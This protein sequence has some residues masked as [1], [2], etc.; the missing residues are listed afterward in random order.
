MHFSKIFRDHPPTPETPWIVPA[1]YRRALW[2]VAGYWQRMS[3]ALGYP[4]C[5]G[6]VCDVCRL[7]EFEAGVELNIIYIS[8][9]ELDPRAL[10]HFRCDDC[11]AEHGDEEIEHD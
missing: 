6:G 5:D 7:D 10:L 4:S 3:P 11:L 1:S 9:R 8:G 2:E